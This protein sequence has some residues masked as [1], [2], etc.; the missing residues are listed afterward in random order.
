[1]GKG[2]RGANC[3]YRKKVRKRFFISDLPFRALS[4]DS[5]SAT[6]QRTH[7]QHPPN[8]HSAFSTHIRR[9][10]ALSTTHA[11]HPE[12]FIMLSGTDGAFSQEVLRLRV[13]YQRRRQASNLCPRR[14]NPSPTWNSPTARH[15]T[16]ASGTKTVVPRSATTFDVP[17]IL[18]GDILRLNRDL[19]CLPGDQGSLN[20]ASA[21]G[22]CC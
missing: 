5:A 17:G 14:A 8:I 21:V 22:G 9:H 2:G 19:P 15:Q 16:R 1:M 11:R 4:L 6:P 13:E 12:R 20:D 18:S 10:M 7:C 3:N